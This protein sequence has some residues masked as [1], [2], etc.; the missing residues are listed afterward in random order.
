[1]SSS[2]Y[3]L[4]AG[5]GYALATSLVMSM[6]AV[7]IKLTAVM[8]SIEMIVFFQYLL[9]VLV[10]LP[11]LRQC[12]LGELRTQRPPAAPDSRPLRLGLFLRLLS[13]TGKDSAGGCGTAEKRCAALRTALAAGVAARGPALAE[14]AS[15]AAGFYRHRSDHAAGRQRPEQL[16]SGWLCL[17][18]DPCRLHRHHPRTDPYRTGE[19]HPVLLLPD[20]DPGRPAACTEQLAATATGQP[21][22]YTADRGFRL[23]DHAALHPLIQPRSSLHHRPP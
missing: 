22:L 6:A 7:L 16:A 14:L 1:M 5:A 13:G 19:P 9:C 18:T 8:I 11:W 23:A 10:M 15:L 20:L 21:A 4:S 2:S 17:R 3:N 12:G